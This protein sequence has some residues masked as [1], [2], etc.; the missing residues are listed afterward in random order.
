[1]G[2]RY[3]EDVQFALNTSKHIY[4]GFTPAFLNFGRELQLLQTF[5]ND[6][7]D[8]DEVK[9][10]EVDKWTER[11]R[12]LQLINE[13]VQKNLNEANE[14]QAKQYNRN[15]L[16]LEF[17]VGYLVMKKNKT[18]SN[19]GL[20]I[21]QKLRKDYEKLYEIIKKISPTIYELGKIVGKG[22]GK[23]IGKWNINDLRKYM[24]DSRK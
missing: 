16:V 9:F 6:I 24:G 20:C 10:Q 2:C 4:T 8:F 18:I 14:N 23:S 3:I 1:M 21:S 13:E 22:V 7:E 15:R 11:L 5:R 19:T 12:K 17:K